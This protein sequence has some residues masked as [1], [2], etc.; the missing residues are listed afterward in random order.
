MGRGGGFSRAP[1]P[2]ILLVVGRGGGLSRAPP[3]VILLC[4]NAAR[5]SLA[6]HHRWL[7]C[8]T[9]TLACCAVLASRGM[10]AGTVAQPGRGRQWRP[11]V[12]T[13]HSVHS[14]HRTS[15][16]NSDQLAGPRSA[17]TAAKVN[18]HQIRY[19]RTAMTNK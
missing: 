8:A 1:P 4:C 6:A 16:D 3:P 2:F 9:T 15:Y 19:D 13:V 7:G 5:S 10:T 14:V 18:V 12:H 11:A 17:S